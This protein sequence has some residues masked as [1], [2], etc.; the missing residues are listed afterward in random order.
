MD[1]LVVTSMRQSG[2]K[3]TAIIGLGKALNKRIAYIKPFGDRMIYSKKRLWDHDAMLLMHVLGIKENPEDIT[4]GFEHSKLKYMYAASP[5]AH[6]IKAH[7][8]IS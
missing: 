5:S 3:T 1:R 6:M 4:L 7:V 2:G 8:F